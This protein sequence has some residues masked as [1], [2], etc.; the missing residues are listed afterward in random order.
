MRRKDEPQPGDKLGWFQDE[1][2][3]WD[4]PWDEDDDRQF[5]AYAETLHELGK[6]DTVDYYKAQK[7]F[8][9]PDTVLNRMAAA[10]L[11]HQNKDRHADR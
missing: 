10:V 5:L 8:E 6:G 11:R 3:N 1:Q 4:R 9:P 7:F 2:G